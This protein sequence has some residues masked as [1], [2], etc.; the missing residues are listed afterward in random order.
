[1][2][3]SN[4]PLLSD[5]PIL[6]KALK[7]HIQLEQTKAMLAVNAELVQLY[8]GIGRMLDVRQTQR[9]WGAAVIPKLSRELANEL[10]EV[11]GFSERNTNHMIAFYRAY[12]KPADFLPQ[13]VAKLEIPT[14]APS[15]ENAIGSRLFPVVLLTGFR[16]Q[17][18]A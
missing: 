8:W 18:T 2:S 10:P 14:K 17:E 11:N 6:L 5:L 7:A 13:A 3:K 12:P 15:S 9:R 4:P 1:M 16:S